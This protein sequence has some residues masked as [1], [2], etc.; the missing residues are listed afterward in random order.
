VEG[1]KFGAVGKA[2]AEE[3]R[4]YGKHADFIGNSDDTRLTGKKFSALVGSRTVLFPQAKS[5]M[6]TIQ[7]QLAK[8]ENVVDLVVYETIKNSE[9]GAPSSEFDIFVFTSP[10]NVETFFGK[11]R[12]TSRQKVVAMGDA[13]ANALRK[14]GLKA[15]KQP[16]SFDDF[17]LAQAVFGI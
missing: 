2:T 11:D 12:I 4:K 7:L 14:F 15:N 16:E 5:S 6:K 9:L 1:V 17:G 8:K 13:T 10:S 3:I